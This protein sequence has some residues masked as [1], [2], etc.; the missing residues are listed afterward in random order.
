MIR[1]KNKRSS[2]PKRILILGSSGIISQNLQEILH[3][4]SYK[5]KVVGSSKINLKKKNAHFFLRKIIKKRDIVVFLS[6][7]APVKTTSAL[8]NNLEMCRNVYDGIDAKIISQLIYISSDAVYSDLKNKISEKSPANPS[9]LHGV[10]HISREKILKSKFE[11][12][13][14]ILRPT[15][16]YGE[17][18]S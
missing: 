5:F 7:E 6:S 12:K 1:F 11:D 9:N 10:M 3:Q 15:M 4:N 14:C 16:I 8:I 13:L 17:R 2:K 18:Y